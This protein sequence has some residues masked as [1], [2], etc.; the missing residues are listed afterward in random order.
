M[1]EC[2]GLLEMVKGGKD[3]S[4]GSIMSIRSFD[5]RCLCQRA[6][7]CLEDCHGQII[8]FA[9][10]IVNGKAVTARSGGWMSF[11]ADVIRQC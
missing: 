9:I 7:G 5:E 10:S 3:L 11:V 4:Q 6:F 1:N 2:L 8:T